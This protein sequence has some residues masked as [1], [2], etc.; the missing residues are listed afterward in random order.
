MAQTRAVVAYTVA[1][2]VGRA[3]LVLAVR[4]EGSSIATPAH[5]RAIDAGTV[6]AAVVRTRGLIAAGSVP[7]VSALALSVERVALAA[8]HAE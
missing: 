5:T 3:A 7:S 4:A 8:A 6:T 1:T 2:A